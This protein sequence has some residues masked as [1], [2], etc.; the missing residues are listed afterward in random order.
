VPAAVISM[1]RKR[2]ISCAAMRTARYPAT[3]A[4]E[5]SASIDCAR[6]I[7]GIASI[8][9]AVAPVRAI[10]ETLSPSVRG[11]RK[12]ISTWSEVRPPGGPGATRATTSAVQG[13]PT[14]PPASV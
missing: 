8:A 4:C 1:G 2:C 12:P 14:E 9:K 7:R 5:D 6:E 10:A 11:A 3:V 13:S